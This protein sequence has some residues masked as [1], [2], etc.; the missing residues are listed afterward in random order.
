MFIIKGVDLFKSILMGIIGYAVVYFICL[1]F[2]ILT[3]RSIGGHKIK[4][5]IK[6]IVS[7]K[8]FKFT[9]STSSKG[10]ELILEVEK[11]LLSV[12]Y[13]IQWEPPS[14]DLLVKANFINEDQKNIIV[15]RIKRGLTGQ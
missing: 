11:P 13:I 12:A 2:T 5:E 15:Q 1:A 10:W 9:Q 6:R 3:S 8:Y 4:K 7:K 14:L